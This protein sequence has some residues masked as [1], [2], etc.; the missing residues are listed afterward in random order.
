MKRDVAIIGGGPAA[1]YAAY[2]FALKYPDIKVVILE[3]G[4]AI[5]FRNCPIIA[6]KTEQCVRCTPCSIMRGFGGAGAFSDGKYNFTTEFGGWL[7]DYLPKKTVMELIDY[8]DE[9]NCRHGAPGKSFPQRTVALGK[10]RWAMTCICST[11]R[12]VIW[13]PIT[14]A[15]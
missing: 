11:R 3:E 13:G 4:H 14:T 6:G 9:I 1:I 10:K 12:S 5:D 8:V 2:E 15:S 7:S